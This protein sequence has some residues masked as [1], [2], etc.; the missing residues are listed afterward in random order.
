MAQTS[1]Q[2][3]DPVKRRQARCAVILQPMPYAL[4]V[5][6]PGLLA[7]E[8]AW[9]GPVG[10]IS[11]VVIALAFLVIALAVALMGKG[12]AEAVKALQKEIAEL[13]TELDPALRGLRDAA[14][15]GRALMLK[16][17]DE[18]EAVIQSSQRIRH[19]VDRGMRRARHRLAD[20]DALAEVMQEEVT[21]TALDVASRVRSFRTGTSVI[22][23]L[24]R[25]FLRGRR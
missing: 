12:I 5:P 14:G 3:R 19:D 6:A 22:G 15:E 23:R 10:A 13:R 7:L 8:A 2:R 21:D 11:L 20:L 18:V 4:L 17:Q 9:V 1:R 16:L 24:R 25:L